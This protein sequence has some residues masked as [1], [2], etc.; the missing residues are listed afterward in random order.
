[1][2]WIATLPLYLGVALLSA[3][4]A[5]AD[6][7]L[8]LPPDARI[9][10]ANRGGIYNWRVIDDKTLLIESQ[11]HHW[12]Q[13]KL[14]SACT[15]L[16]FAERVGFEANADG[17]FDKFSAITVGRERCPL[18]SLVETAA[19]AKKRAAKQPPAP[20]AAGHP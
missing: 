14:F 7:T 16:P 1:M 17:S 9:P 8:S 13:A 4:T 6:A 19:P 3:A 20:A 2:R 18:I 15:K 12:Y 5:M 11:S 10:L